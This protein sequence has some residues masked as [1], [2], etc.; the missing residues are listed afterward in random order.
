MREALRAV[1]VGDF[2]KLR[3]VKLLNKPDCGTAAR[4]LKQLE[5]L[6]RPEAS[7]LFIR[8]I[9]SLKTVITF[10]HP[11]LVATSNVFLDR[12]SKRM[13]EV[14]EGG[15]GWEEINVWYKSI[16]GQVSQKTRTYYLGDSAGVRLPSFN[17]GWINA[18]TDESRD[19]ERAMQECR[20]AKFVDGK[21]KGDPRTQITP[22]DGKKPRLGD[23]NVQR[24]KGVV[25]GAHQQI[26]TDKAGAEM[27]AFV[28]AHPKVKK[29]HACW[30]FFHAQGCKMGN[31]CRFHHVEK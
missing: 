12:F 7:A 25:A 10:A 9:S 2:L 6:S 8:A 29:Q 13:T 1:R 5:S 20:V 26:P 22:G 31:K 21:R 27:S 23:A 16:F 15:V 4:P 19:L 24:A 11:T 28:K 17:I 3:V 14:I 18:D 30:N